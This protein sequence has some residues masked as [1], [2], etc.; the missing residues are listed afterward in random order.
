LNSAIEQLKADP[1]NHHLP[2]RIISVINAM[3]SGI[4][5][6]QREALRKVVAAAADPGNSPAELQSRRQE[7]INLLESI[8]KEIVKNP[9]VKG[10]E[11]LIILEIPDRNIPEGLY[12]FSGK[13]DL[14]VFLQSK[15]IQ[16]PDPEIHIPEVQKAEMI[17]TSGHFP[18]IQVPRQYCL[19][20]RSYGRI[21]VLDAGVLKQCHAIYTS[22][23]L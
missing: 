8:E 4:S 3:K 22:Q 5:D 2:Q 21:G 12:K 7:L 16:I 6:D 11:K 1:N 20:R 23:G 18:Q 9:P 14:Q 19:I 17:F 10:S 13:E 15:G